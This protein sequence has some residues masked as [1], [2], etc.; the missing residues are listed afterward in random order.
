MLRSVNFFFRNCLQDLVHQHTNTIPNTM[1]AMHDLTPLP[2]TNGASY[3]GANCTQYNSFCLLKCICLSKDFIF[4]N[5][6]KPFHENS[7]Q[8]DDT[9]SK[10]PS[11]LK[12]VH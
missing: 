2:P 6:M 7:L 3:I 10:I 11:C 1:L 12:F 8:K 4:A 5:V 9:A